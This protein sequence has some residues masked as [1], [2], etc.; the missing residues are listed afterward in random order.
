M[1]FKAHA[2]HTRTYLQECELN[3][4][5]KN[6]IDLALLDQHL[7]HMYEAMREVKGEIDS[8][9]APQ[10]GGDK[11]FGLSAPTPISPKLIFEMRARAFLGA[12]DAELLKVNAH[13]QKILGRALREFEGLEKRVKKRLKE[14]AAVLSEMASLA[15]TTKALRKRV[16]AIQQFSSVNQVG[17]LKITKAYDKATGQHMAE[18]L[19]SKMAGMPFYSS[20]HA[21]MLLSRITMV[22]SYFRELRDQDKNF[23]A[24]E[25]LGATKRERRMALFTAGSFA[26]STFYMFGIIIIFGFVTDAF[27]KLFPP[28]LIAVPS[29]LFGTALGGGVMLLCCRSRVN[30][31]LLLGMERGIAEESNYR[32][33]LRSTA[34]F[35]FLIYLF[36]IH[37]MLATFDL[38]P[39]ELLGIRILTCAFD[40]LVAGIL[41]ISVAICPFN[42]FHRSFRVALFGA[43]CRAAAAPFTDSRLSLTLLSDVISSMPTVAHFFLHSCCT[44]LRL[45]T[46]HHQRSHCF[47]HKTLNNVSLPYK[48]IC[49]CNSGWTFHAGGCI[50][51]DWLILPLFSALPLWVRLMQCAR[52]LWCQPSRV[53]VLNVARYLLCLVTVLTS[54]LGGSDGSI[55][56]CNGLHYKGDATCTG[57]ER[58]GW[59]S[60]WVA[61]SLCSM[62]IV[63][64][65]DVGGLGI[66]RLDMRPS[67]SACGPHVRATKRVLLCDSM[68][69]HQRRM[70]RIPSRT[71][72]GC[73]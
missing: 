26:G 23:A 73:G 65:S 43:I 42:L 19:I 13:Y 6:Y 11:D 50:T 31:A 34:I 30:Y 54:T 53:H 22:S 68:G 46:N 62:L 33:L 72:P 55:Y 28:M 38:V 20:Q 36:T 56:G 70:L 21:T 61:T 51:A 41:L 63:W 69:S 2:T 1:E 8:P 16:K 66:R 32:S 71:I 45:A 35:M 47:G 64:V 48:E 39:G 4:G 9:L 25:R 67:R 5:A 40:P 15:N 10:E 18:I 14:G 58:A 24:L 37:Y 52:T 44:C 57:D 49:Q 27:L 59:R 17:F 3:E 12:L 7:G 60:L 29:L